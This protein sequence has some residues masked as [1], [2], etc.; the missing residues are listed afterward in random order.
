[1]A[2]RIVK[3]KRAKKT[4]RRKSTK[5][6]PLPKLFHPGFWKNNWKQTA[7]LAALS[8]I[9]YVQT[10]PYEYV[11]DDQI[12]ITGNDFTQKGI[13][14]IK[15][16]F[17]TESFHGYFGEQK[18]LLPG[19]RYRPLSIAT[20]AIEYELFGFNSAVG[21]LV[22]ALLYLLTGLLLFRIFNLLFPSKKESVWFFNIAFVASLLFVLHPLHTEAVAN[23][24]GR[25]EIIALL[26]CLG[27]L[28]YALKYADDQKWLSIFL[29]G[30][31]FF[32][33]IMSKEI[34]I[35]FLAII[36]F[37][38]YFFTGRDFKTA[39]KAT[40]PA[41]VATLLYLL[42]RYMVLGYL[43]SSGSQMNDLMNNPFM[44]MNSSERAATK[45][46]ILGLY[47]KLGFF[48]HP[49]THDYYPFHIPTMDW[50]KIASILS[51]LLYFVL[52]VL[53][54]WGLRKKSIWAFCLIVYLAPLTLVSNIFFTVGTFM[55]E[56]FLYFS[57]IGICLFLGYLFTEKLPKWKKPIGKYIAYTLTGLYV[58]GFFY[59]SFTRIPAWRTPL[60]LNS[61][62]VKVSKNSARVNTFMGTALFNEAKETDDKTKRRELVE[63]ADGYITK[64]IQ[65]Y[66]K[67]YNANLMKAGIV[68]EIYR[69]DFN[70]AKLLDDFK[71]IASRR[72][73]IKYLHEYF[74]YLNSKSSDYQI[75]LN[76]YY[77]TGYNILFK[78]NRDY[79]WALHYLNY[80]LSVDANNKQV[81]LAMS[82]VYQAAGDSK[83]AN[84]YA[85]RA[86][87]AG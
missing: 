20:F 31:C 87:E 28:Y 26:G 36:P 80:A 11:L 17:T 43:F 39:L 82:E 78:R 59:Q 38:I 34:S 7:I 29:S 40:M 64:S 4:A 23:V 6:A 27:G 55:N 52:G 79:K 81:L 67:Y 33:G 37:A 32:L 76:F 56:R 5:K 24:K 57:T 41:F 75:L 71:S 21:H 58:I 84:L 83:N 18:D 54:L 69:F 72:P 74:D 35:T 62:A 8:L 15:D 86:R 14:G 1:M 30:F 68:A 50:T 60:T 66:P 12:V 19:S 9:L 46:Y 70:L 51:L 49:L 85:Q 2:K 22:N 45:T 48:P 13:A 77:D 42:I 63:Q 16:I 47:F 53:T 61:A 44:G 65:L 10:M 3:N 73:D 25:D